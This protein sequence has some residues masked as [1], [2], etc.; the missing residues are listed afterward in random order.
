VVIAMPNHWLTQLAWGDLKLKEAIHKVVS[1]YDLPAHYF[2]IS[3]LFKSNWWAKF[4][5]PGDFWMMEMFNGCCAYNEAYRWRTYEKT[6]PEAV[7][8]DEVLWEEIQRVVPSSMPL[9]LPYEVGVID[10]DVKVSIVD[11][12]QIKVN[13]NMQFMEGANSEANEDICGEGKV[14]F[15]DSRTDA[16]DWRPICY[17]EAVERRDMEN[18]TDYET[19]HARANRAERVLR[20]RM[21]GREDDK[22]EEHGYALS[23]LLG[24]Q[25]ALLMCAFNQD[26]EAITRHLIDSLPPDWRKEAEDELL[27]VSVDSFVGSVNAQPGGWPAEELRGEHSPAPKTH[28]GLFLAGDFFFDSTLNGVL[29]SSAIAV[30]LLLEYLGVEGK[31]GTEAIQGLQTDKTGV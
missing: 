26:E 7:V 4:K 18:G 9:V 15:L 3:M 31:P 21:M 29:M 13:V 11:G 5:F 20:L 12:D 10:G 2:R 8:I 16:K 25:D 19:A 23:F 22:K 28:P 6:D 27:E 24:G 1:H 17:H 30:D 14:I